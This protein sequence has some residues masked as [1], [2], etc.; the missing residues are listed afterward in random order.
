MH[1]AADRTIETAADL[2]GASA[3]A[4]VRAAFAARGRA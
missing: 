3:E 2:Y 1:A 4:A